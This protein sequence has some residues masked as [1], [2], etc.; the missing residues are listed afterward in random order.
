MMIQIQNR[1][2]AVKVLRF[3]AVDA[4]RR[5]R[6]PPQRPLGVLGVDL[7]ANLEHGRYYFRVATETVLAGYEA[8][9]C[10]VIAFRP[11]A[12][13]TPVSAPDVGY[14]FRILVVG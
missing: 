14:R 1:R 10:A 6:R 9:E 2:R 7:A 3:G 13:C 12:G 11:A 5:P 8:F 4:H